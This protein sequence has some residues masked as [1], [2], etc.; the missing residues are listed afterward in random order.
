MAIETNYSAVFSG[1]TLIER[2]T[3]QTVGVTVTRSGTD[4]TITSA[5]V[6]LYKPNGDAVIDAQ[7]ATVAGGLVTYD[8]GSAVLSSEAYGQAWL[9]RFDVVISSLSYSFYNDA[10]LCL[11]RI[12]PPIGTSAL[13]DRHGDITNL[14]PTGTTSPQSYIDSAWVELLGRLYSDAIPFWTLRTVSALRPPL[15]YAALHLVFRDFATMIDPGDR[16]A[17]LADHYEIK[18]RKEYA[19]MRGFFDNSQDNQAS[20]ERKPGSPLLR[21]S[22]GRRR[23]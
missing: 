16:Y 10:V 21:L 22:S 9:L 19:K 4:A 1:P 2:D 18:A 6:T 14:L 12:F 7:T 5:T 11:S 3:A 23:V 8:I 13:T 17:E 20:T 15:L